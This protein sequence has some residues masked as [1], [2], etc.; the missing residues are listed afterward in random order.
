MNEVKTVQ[1]LNL[2]KRNIIKDIIFT[3]LTL[4]IY[5]IYWL[6]KI[7]KNIRQLE[8]SNKSVLGEML[9]YIFIPFYSWYWVYNRGEKISLLTQNYPRPMESVSIGTLLCVIFGLDFIA[10]VMFQ[11]EI[12]CF[13][14]NNVPL[15]A[16]EC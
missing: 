1:S 8:C 9:L 3:I 6:Y 5:K 7:M 13:V 10:F 16:K 4:G 12:N 11:D 2:E 14:D 15:N